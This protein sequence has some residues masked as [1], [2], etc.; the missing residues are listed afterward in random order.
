M[1]LFETLKVQPE[2]E[3]NSVE[4]VQATVV[5][6]RASASINVTNKSRYARLVR[7]RAEWN[8]GQ[9]AAPN[10]VIFGDNY[11]DLM[12]HESRAVEV[13]FFLPE[14]GQHAAR[15]RLVIEGS[16][17]KAVEVPIALRGQG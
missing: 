13:E 4:S 15:G 10:L 14:G 2:A 8:E 16:N 12:P 9:G 17:L 5:D 3:L 11:F 7:M 6:S 1:P